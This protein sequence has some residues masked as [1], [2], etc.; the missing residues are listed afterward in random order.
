MEILCVL[1]HGVAQSECADHTIVNRHITEKQLA[2]DYDVATQHEQWRMARGH[3]CQQHQQIYRLNWTSAVTDLLT[4]LCLHCLVNRS[5][6]TEGWLSTQN[7]AVTCRRYWAGCDSTRTGGTACR[8]DVTR[9]ACMRRRQSPW[10][11]HQAECRQWM[12]PCQSHHHPTCYDTG[13]T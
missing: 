10:C 2:C 1:L 5:I 7:V 9:T 3:R 13:R 8:S 11:R 4:R 12:S 6:T